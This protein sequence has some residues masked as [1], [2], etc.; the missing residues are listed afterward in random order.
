MIKEK[1]IIILNTEDND[2]I[3]Y[4]QQ[5]VKKEQNSTQYNY[6]F[7]NNGEEALQVL[8]M[9][10]GGILIFSISTKKALT[11]LAIFLK[12]GKEFIEKKLFRVAGFNNIEKKKIEKFLS[13]NLVMD[14]LNSSIT[15][16]G[17]KFKF[18]LW[19]KA[20]ESAHQAHS[21]LFNTK[22]ESTSDEKNLSTKHAIKN[23]IKYLSPLKIKSDCWYF[24]SSEHVK[25]MMGSWLVEMVGP[26]PVAGHWHEIVKKNDR[27]KTPNWKWIPASINLFQF[28]LEDGMWVFRG[29]EPIFNWETNRWK[30]SGSSPELFF[31]SRKNAERKFYIENKQLVICSEL[32]NNK[33]KTD[34]INESFDPKYILGEKERLV[35]PTFESEEEHIEKYLK[36]K[37]EDSF[38]ESE[39]TE[40]SSIKGEKEEAKDN[41]KRGKT[42]RANRKRYD[43]ELESFQKSL[44]D[45]LEVDLQKR[46]NSKDLDIENQLEVN[47]NRERKKK[48]KNIKKSHS[49]SENID[50]KLRGRNSS[51]SE[52]HKRKSKTQGYTEELADISSDLTKEFNEDLDA[53]L[54]K[55]INKKDEKTSKRNRRSKGQKSERLGHLSGKLDTTEVEEDDDIAGLDQESIDEIKNVIKKRRDSNKNQKERKEKQ[56]EREKLKIASKMDQMSE[57]F[58]AS[59]DVP[60]DL[61]FEDDLAGKLADFEGGKPKRERKYKGKDR[62]KKE[63]TKHSPIKESDFENIHNQHN[64]L[65]NDDLGDFSE[66]DKD[67][68]KYMR[69]QQEQKENNSKSSHYR[70]TNR[71]NKSYE[72]DDPYGTSEEELENFN[73]D[74][75]NDFEKSEKKKDDEKNK[76]KKA[77]KRYMD[78][79][80]SV[81]K[82]SKER[83]TELIGTTS[84]NFNSISILIK[85]RTKTS[86]SNEFSEEKETKLLDIFDDIVVLENITG[87]DH[88]VDQIVAINCQSTYGSKTHDFSLTGEII[89]IDSNE[90]EE[91]LNIQLRKFKQ[92]DLEELSELFIE[93][94]RNISNFLNLSQ[95]LE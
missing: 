91:L 72:G 90:D 12:E 15:D 41:K 4:F 1:K 55:F 36:G 89:E 23:K 49:T 62:S 35:Q 3:D 6:V 11:E 81:E 75:D 5:F 84:V 39:N 22:S 47:K 51:D 79:L 33:R 13:D 43:S 64:D 27:K 60:V 46:N 20:I 34:L 24:Q 26:G 94:Q 14:I 59:I 73:L 83:P 50:N 30:F 54:D 8:K 17:I 77:L 65:L 38:D 32:E 44:N 63:K 78:G 67:Y 71:K 48:D 37:L 87:D 82:K 68:D 9:S 10:E 19:F 93:R 21:H 16:K 52:S 85:I 86:K 2:Q 61:D 40:V 57:I 92:K 58:D 66:I 70:N 29:S 76:R 56:A 25:Y 28:I 88:F 95:G 45:E 18:N 7:V 69:S 31:Y 42:E 74:L 80:E 53:E